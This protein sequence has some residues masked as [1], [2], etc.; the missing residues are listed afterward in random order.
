MNRADVYLVVMVAALMMS[1]VATWASFTARAQV[2]N[3][4]AE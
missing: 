4:A 1:G 2:E 3:D